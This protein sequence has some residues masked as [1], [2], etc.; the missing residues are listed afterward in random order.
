MIQFIHVRSMTRSIS[1]K[2]KKSFFSCDHTG[3]SKNHILNGHFCASAPYDGTPKKYNIGTS[4]LRTARLGSLR[5]RS[6]LASSGNL[7]IFAFAKIL[8]LIFKKLLYLWIFIGINSR[9][10]FT[11]PQ[12][13]I[14]LFQKVAVFMDFYRNKFRFKLFCFSY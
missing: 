2:R 5:A 11:Q 6:S 8:Q 9:M 12:V 10:F 13:R 7:L 3:D 14:V 1:K 4:S